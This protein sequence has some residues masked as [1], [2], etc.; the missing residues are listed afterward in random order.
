MIQNLKILLTQAV[1]FFYRHPFDKIQIIMESIDGTLLD[2]KQA[3]E[4]VKFQKGFFLGQLRGLPTLHA[5][6]E[7][8]DIKSNN[9]QKKYFFYVKP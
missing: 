4:F 5:I 9:I 7:I 8:H 3:S 6:L 1:P 2:K